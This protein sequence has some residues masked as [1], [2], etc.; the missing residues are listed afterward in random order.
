MLSL[1][2]PAPDGII[3]DQVQDALALAAASVLLT[4]SGDERIPPARGVVGLGSTV[5]APALPMSLQRTS[6]PDN[7]CSPV[8]YVSTISSAAGAACTSG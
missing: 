1:M 5:S 8:L 6:Y 4:T 3:N 7:R 2:M